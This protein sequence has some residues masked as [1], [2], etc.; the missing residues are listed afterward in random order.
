LRLRIFFSASSAGFS[1]YLPHGDGLVSAALVRELARRGH[2]IHIA[3][4][5]FSLREPMPSNVILHR[6][7]AGRGE[8]FFDRL[9]YAFRA[10][11]LFNTLAKQRPFDIVHQLNPVIA[12]L[13]LGFLFLSPPL[14]LGSYIENWKREKTTSG[15]SQVLKAFFA[16]R[17][18]DTLAGIQQIRARRIILTTHTA[19]NRVPLAAL[20][21]K[22]LCV[23]PHGIDVDG[24]VSC[25]RD[26]EAPPTIL[27]LAS[28]I[29]RKGILTLIKAFEL[30]AS[31]LPTSRL[32]VAGSGSALNEARRLVDELSLGSR[33]EFVGAV[34][35]EDMSHTM[36][37][38]T[39]YCLPSHGEPFGMTVLEAMACGLPVVVTQECGLG[40]IVPADAGRKVPMRDPVALAEGLSDLLGM[41]RAQLDAI[42]KRNREYVEAGFALPRVVD[43]LEELYR[44]IVAEQSTGAARRPVG[45]TA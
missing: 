32:L 33:V 10:R 42:G 36:A 20:L 25:A 4:T 19:R 14:V 6:I 15:F 40:E 34:G 45:T 21:A 38:A 16:D 44:A 30:V 31:R 27:F 3:G 11:R 2:D 26:A 18:R 41:S 9:L 1:D 43:R 5:H 29:P 23:I 28:V 35:R 13:S 37:R 12:G 22:K 17:V 39:V 24:L 7:D 8:R